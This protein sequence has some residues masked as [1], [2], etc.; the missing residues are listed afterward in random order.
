[1]PEV[2]EVVM[3]NLVPVICEIAAYARVLEQKG[4]KEE[5]N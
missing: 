4:V 5:P 2:P 3:M 1:M